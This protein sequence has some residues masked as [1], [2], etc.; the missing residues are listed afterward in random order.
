MPEFAPE[1]DNAAKGDSFLR[2]YLAAAEWLLDDEID[3]AKLRGWTR[4]AL[5]SARDDCERF[6][7]EN[8][9]NLD[10]YGELYSPRGGYSVDEC[11]GHDFWLSRNG[12]GSGFF[13]RGGEPVFDRLQSAARSFG[14]C[15]PYESRGWLYFVP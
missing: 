2:G 4:A 7:R 15:D 1:F 3:R 12:H 10:E 9:A 8:A 14:E 5:K 11:A 6:Q 13:D